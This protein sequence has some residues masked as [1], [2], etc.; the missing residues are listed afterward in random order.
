MRVSPV[1]GKMSAMSTTHFTS[2]SASGP[3]RL[4]FIG[5][6]GINRVHKELLLREP[7]SV[8]MAG[9]AD[10]VSALA[11]AL[12]G[13]FNAPVFADYTTM[14]DA[15]AGQ[16]DA[17][18]V[19]TPHF[20]HA[21]AAAAALKRGL[22]VLL[23]K[24]AVC[25]MEELAMLQELEKSSGAFV[26]VCHQQRFG[27]EENWLKGW[28]QGP[29]FGEPRLFNIDIYQ[30]IEGYVSDKPDAWILDKNQ[31]GG[32]IVISVGIHILDLLR[33]W[34]DDD[35]VEVCAYG[36][37]DAPFKN[38][39]ESTVAATLRTRRGMIGTLNCSYGV[40]RCPYSQ[41]ALIFGTRGTL[42]QHLDPI[43]GGYAGPYFIATDGGKPTP[44]W[45]DMYAGWQK[46]ADRMAGAPDFVPEVHPASFV[47]QMRHFLERVRAGSPGQNSLTIHHNT[48]AI[49][50]AIGR[51]LL[52]GKPESVSSPA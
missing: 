12:G 18:L 52:S 20:L 21:P 16:V 10:P 50:D 35:Y 5:A 1:A 2:T 44:V 37:F 13:E 7:G 31:A 32:G 28:L 26:Q 40:K 39:A 34:F 47:N 15:L 14:L 42:A 51:S 46:V 4:A 33:Y 29:D 30:N 45:N 25:T 11:G 27:Q 36:R 8:R 41:R 24:P 3:L 49:V 48:A 43:G 9:V 19:T 23:E 6:G 17:V 38:G 22:P